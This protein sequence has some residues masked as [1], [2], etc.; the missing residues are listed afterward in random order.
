MVSKSVFGDR[1]LNVRNELLL[2]MCL[3]Y[4]LSTY[5]LHTG[6]VCN[7][8]F[9]SNWYDLRAIAIS[10]FVRHGPYFSDYLVTPK[11]VIRLN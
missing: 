1:I 10:F 11:L 8:Y 2:N 6:Y 7:L 4:K 9:R 3:L 5:V